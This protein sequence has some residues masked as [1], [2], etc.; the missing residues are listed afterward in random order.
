MQR[1]K[2]SV[3][4]HEEKGRSQHQSLTETL[5]SLNIYGMCAVLA[6]TEERFYETYHV[7]LESTTQLEQTSAKKGGWLPH[8]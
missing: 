7:S 2:W 1:L 4:V 8:D 3:L 6:R 5:P